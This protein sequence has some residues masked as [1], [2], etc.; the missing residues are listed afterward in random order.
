MASLEE[1][2]VRVQTELGALISRPKLT[3]K[4]L[5]KPPFRFLHDIVSAVT[6]ATGFGAGIFSGAELNGAEITERDAKCAYLQKIIDATAAAAGSPLA[7]RPSKIVAG[8]EPENTNQWLIV[9][10]CS[11]HAGTLMRHHSV[12]YTENIAA[13]PLPSSG[14]S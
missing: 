13:A 4:L 1:L 2:V 5:S 3:E 11:G 8:A 12:G 14:V 7:A 9:S 6:E 10:A